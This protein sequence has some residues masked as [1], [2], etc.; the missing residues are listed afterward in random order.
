M[1]QLFGADNPKSTA[2][3]LN[4]NTKMNVLC[5]GEMCPLSASR[6][7]TI[8]TWRMSCKVFLLISIHLLLQRL[9]L[10]LSILI[11]IVSPIN[12][13]LFVVQDVKENRVSYASVVWL[14]EQPRLRYTAHLL[15]TI[16]Y[17][18]GEAPI[19]IIATRRIVTNQGI[20]NQLTRLST[21]IV[22]I[23]VT[24]ERPR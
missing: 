16:I 14:E 9:S 6:S 12:C 22:V 18:T 8:A 24:L 20:P 15:A 13:R 17:K 11:S 19:V 21:V 23:V 2:V 1:W 7:S 4:T 3:L 10:P 5:V